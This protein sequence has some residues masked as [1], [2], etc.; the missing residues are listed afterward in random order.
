MQALDDFDLKLLEFL[1]QNNRLT[2]EELG[3]EV[4]LSTSAVQRRLK[5]LRLNGVIVADVAVVNKEVLGHNLSCIIDVS[6][7]LGN[8]TVID[9]FK[10][11]MLSLP[12]VSQCH[13]V[14]GSVD[15][16]VMTHFADMKA[17][18]QFSRKYLMDNP[19]VKQFATHVLIDTVKFHY[20][21]LP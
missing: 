10:K 11:L 18:E 16:F 2:A 19:D 8:S 6:L 21:L 14:A 3:E 12:E 1:Q 20:G 13:Y 9:K 15:F 5:K 4:G 17:F 7:H